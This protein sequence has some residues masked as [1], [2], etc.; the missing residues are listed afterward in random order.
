MSALSNSTVDPVPAFPAAVDAH[1]E[2]ERRVVWDDKQYANEERELV[3]EISWIPEIG[4]W[5]RFLRSQRKV[6]S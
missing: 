3:Y 5:R 1:W 2:T 4:V 6:R